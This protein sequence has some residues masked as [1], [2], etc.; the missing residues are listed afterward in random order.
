MSRSPHALC[1]IAYYISRI[2][3]AAVL[4][5]THFLLL[6][7]RNKKRFHQQALMEVTILD[8]LRRRDKHGDYNVIHM[9]DYFYFRNHLC[10]TFQ[11]MG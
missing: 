7:D 5:L 10:V 9:L 1:R 8:H 6:F 2:H 11:L 3:I 4:V